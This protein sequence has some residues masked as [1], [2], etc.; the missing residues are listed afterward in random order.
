MRF[1][2][3][4]WRAPLA[5]LVALVLQAALLG[6]GGFSTIGINTCI[7]AL[8]ALAAGPLFG[9]LRRLPGA[10]RVWFR[11]GLVGIS[12]LVLMLSLVNSTILLSTEFA[13]GM[14]TT[15]ANEVTFHPLTLMAFGVLAVIAAVLERRLDHTPEFP[16][17]LL[18]GELSVLGTVILHCLVLIFGGE[19][20]WQV[21]ALIDL[22]VHLPIAVIE[23]VVLGFTVGFLA[24]VKPE[25]L[26]WRSRALIPEEEYP[27]WPADRE[28]ARSEAITTKE[29]GLRKPGNWSLLFALAG[30]LVVPPSSAHAH[31]LEAGTV[32]RPFWQVQVESWFETHEP[33]AGA[34]AQV[35]RS[36]GRLL[37][38]GTLTDKGI[39]IFSYQHIDTF[40]VVVSAGGGHRAEA[41]VTADSLRPNAVCTCVACLGSPLAAVPLLVPMESDSPSPAPQ[42]LVARRSGA[43]LQ[44][45]LIGVSILGGVAM[46]AVMWG[47][48]R[49]KAK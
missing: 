2:A 45:L 22:V 16:L 38:A 21:W 39:F 40:T 42:P 18:V 7:M 29:E 41:I 5:I 49:Q 19:S 20:N 27:F 15:L 24:R 37:T 11:A 26:G 23:G 32:V 31:R 34:R 46:L 6:H 3:S 10:R 30:W 9:G 33:A 17:G 25:M 44:N 28:G 1:L 13:G 36:N 48:L 35:F 4:R 12:A 14:N 8:P 43:Q 47:R